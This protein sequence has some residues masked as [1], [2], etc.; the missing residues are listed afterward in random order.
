MS[1]KIRN[2]EAFS[3]MKNLSIFMG[4]ERKT[5]LFGSVLSSFEIINTMIFPFIFQKM[6]Q[7]VSGDGKQSEIAVMMG[8]LLVVLCITPIICYGSFIRQKS[9][10][11][12]KNNMR[13]N[14]FFHIQNLS[15]AQTQGKNTGEYITILSNDVTKA[16]GILQG[17]GIKSI[18]QGIVV[19]PITAGIL[20][21]HSWEIALIAILFSV[22]C[23]GISSIF[24]PKVSKLGQEAQQKMGSTADHLLELV[25][26]F[27]MVR[28]FGVYERLLKK[29][30]STCREIFSKRIKFR[31]LNGIV[32]AFLNFFQAAAQPFAF[33][34]GIFL[35]MFF[36]SDIATIVLVSGIA[37]VMAASARGVGTFIA[38]MQPPLVSARRIF[39]VFD[40]EQEEKRKTKTAIPLQD[41]IALS[42]KGISFSY[43]TSSEKK[44]ILNNLSCDIK[45]D[46]IIA[47]VGLS[48]CGKSTLFKLLQ[49]FYEPHEG[50]I[51]YFGVS[52]KEIS[53]DDIRKM[54]AYVPQDCNL[55]EGS[56]AYNISL[57][58]PQ[59]S[60]DEINL[61]AK[62]ANLEDF[63]AQQKD[64]YDALVG[65]K[66]SQL[67]GG[68]RQRIA[69]ARA[70]LKDAPI[71]LLDEATSALDIESEHE[72]LAALSNLMQN[73]TTL[74]ISHRL[75]SIQHV[76][77]IFVMENGEIIEVGNHDELLKKQGLYFNLS[78]NR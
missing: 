62:N 12:G 15:I 75:S 10:I 34:I 1:N 57:G 46:E 47:F 49:E 72:V 65:E 35:V 48:G 71:L 60:M 17:F 78:N 26:G 28:I 51:L 66:G 59:A 13:K 7:V 69:I 55:F 24:N 3:L 8:L 2:K 25:S 21:Y 29:F 36:R 5:Y 6:I 50:D 70:F 39:A 37:G 77:R 38:N 76:D 27:A 68:Q 43:D 16:Y 61:A 64:G 30:T 33:I 19:F 9:F 42:I 32:D 73:R 11:H 41:E 40:L 44:K 22:F 67:S 4:K 54:I 56:I 20:F 53:K 23:I 52:R 74:M 58:N 45:K 31:T 63:I 14:L 18:F